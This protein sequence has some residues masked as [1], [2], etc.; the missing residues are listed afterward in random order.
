MA[1]LNIEVMDIEDRD[2]KI[3]DRD[4]KIAELEAENKSLARTVD[5]YMNES[6]KYK[7]AFKAIRHLLKG[8]G[9]WEK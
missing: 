3:K 1:E 6:L 4:E 7:D 9:I 8:A 2:A 5:Y